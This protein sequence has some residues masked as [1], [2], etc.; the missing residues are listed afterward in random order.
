MKITLKIIKIFFINFILLCLSFSFV[1]SVDY[2]LG[3]DGV[4]GPLRIVVSPNFNI[5]L[6]HSA[7]NSNLYYNTNSRYNVLNYDNISG[8][9][10]KHKSTSNMDLLSHS[11]NGNQITTVAKAQDLILTQVVTYQIGMSKYYMEFNILNNGTTNVSNI[12]F[13]TGGDTYFADSDSS[14]S[15]FNPT[16]G[17]I[18]LKNANAETSGIMGLY[19]V[20]STPISGYYGGSYSESDNW[21]YNE[22]YG[23]FSNPSFVDAGYNVRWNNDSTLIPGDSWTIYAEEQVTGPDKIQVISPG[24]VSTFIK[25]EI[26]Y[27]F[28]ILNF[29]DIDSNFNFLISSSNDWDIS[30]DITSLFIASGSSAE[31]VVGITIPQN[32]SVNTT[33]ILKLIAIS[34][35]SGNNNSNYVSTY[36]QV[37]D[38]SSLNYEFNFGNISENSSSF[39]NINFSLRKEPTTDVNVSFDND[40]IFNFIENEFIFNTNNW[41]IT[42]SLEFNIIN[43]YIM[44]IKFVYLFKILINNNIFIILLFRHYR[45]Y[46]SCMNPSRVRGA[47][48]LPQHPGLQLLSPFRLWIAINLTIYYLI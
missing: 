3:D 20:G 29:E 34:D 28:T 4:T 17:M 27:T 26:N 6:Y 48:R 24:R 39:F 14:R 2:E 22:G 31:V 42:Q 30:I 1:N 11:Q 9:R 19:G 23:N 12:M 43:N 38:L 10:L 25:N 8:S 35:V 40:L 21:L 15:Y 46:N 18:Y 36:Y 45:A 32:V 13:G 41:N 7:Y 37:H 47:L 5:D 16:L 44:E 33:D